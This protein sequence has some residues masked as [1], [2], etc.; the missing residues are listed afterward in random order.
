MTRPVTRRGLTMP[1]VAVCVVL[2]NLGVLGGLHALFPDLSLFPR[3]ETAAAAP[4]QKPSPA[5]ALR[6]G[7]L[8][9]EQVLAAVFASDPATLPGSGWQAGSDPGGAPGLP[10]DFACGTPDG[11]SAVVVESRG[12][13][14]VS[15]PLPTDLQAAITVSVRAYGAGG[16]GLAMESLRTTLGDCD[17]VTSGARSG[18]G[19]EAISARSGQ[20][21]ALVW[22]RGD[23]IGALTYQVGGRSGDL[24]AVS[25]LAAE[26]DTRLAAALTGACVSMDSTAADATRS[27]YLSRAAFTGRTV[28]VP[29]ALDQVAAAAAE[30]R[31]A[32]TTLS[33]PATPTVT[34]AP[35]TPAV[36]TPPSS[37]SMP[38]VT[39]HP[40]VP[41]TIPAPDLPLPAEVKPL[42]ARPAGVT[43][44]VVVPT[45]VDRPKPPT[46]PTAAPAS[47]DVPSR[48]ADPDGPG[49]GWAFTGQAAP[50]FDAVK[51]AA[52][53]VHAKTAAQ[54]QLQADW[55]QWL[56][57]RDAYYVAY[58][59]YA[60]KAEVYLAY[61]K[62]IEAIRTAWTGVTDARTAYD[63][64]M[65]T[66]QS[67][68]AARDA[69]LAEQSAARAAYDAA[70]QACSSPTPTP[71]PTPSPT[72]TPT[73][74]AAPT[75]TPT[76]GPSCPPVRPAILDQQA[77]PV[78][79]QPTPPAT[80]PPAA[81]N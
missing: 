78:P 81:G 22:R 71:T 75:P 72:P 26:Y 35:A 39:P 63:A 12:W 38:T 32:A 55:V 16:G 9:A 76:P 53:L 43:D 2:V 51:A 1:L 28:P 65:R 19:V 18:L 69:F 44:P 57:A 11:P 62:V 45:K 79:V 66:Y 64:A 30:A 80:A 50:A 74:T 23:V 27:P 67:A 6:T 31:A 40:V 61:S 59:D 10:F 13:A 17:A 7:P 68:V 41:V 20:T 37:F 34:A 3:A 33:T 5:V 73:P 36:T 25:A 29:V 14:Q 77:P 46:A 42:P 4:E 8:P 54:V 52:D 24:L 15:G 47:I 49:C 58:A 21:A 56:T 70:V 48:V 60:T